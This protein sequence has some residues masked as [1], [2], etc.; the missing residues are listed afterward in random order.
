MPLTLL[1]GKEIKWWQSFEWGWWILWHEYQWFGMN[2]SFC[3]F[4]STTFLLF[5]LIVGKQL[6]AFLSRNVSRDR[7]RQLLLDVHAIPISER[8]DQMIRDVRALPSLT[9]CISLSYE[10]NTGLECRRMQEGAYL[11]LHLRRKFGSLRLIPPLQWRGRQHQRETSIKCMVLQFCL[12][13]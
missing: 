1:T 3:C 7:F 6:R 11:S 13:R 2:L 5:L 8:L 10:H 12:S 4:Y 9:V